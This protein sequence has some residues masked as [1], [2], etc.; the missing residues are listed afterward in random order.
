MAT[1]AVSIPAS[2][3]APEAIA[4]PLDRSNVMIATIAPAM[5]FLRMSSFPNNPAR[6]A[7]IIAI[8]IFP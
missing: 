8:T 2:D 5:T 4:N 6:I 1:I 7:S 3:F